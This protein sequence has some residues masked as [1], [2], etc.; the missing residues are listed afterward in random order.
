MLFDPLLKPSE[1]PV[2]APSGCPVCVLATIRSVV[3]AKPA[4]C[5]E[6]EGIQLTS[7][8]AVVSKGISA[9][10]GDGRPV[11]STVRAVGPQASQLVPK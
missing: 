3:N 6:G 2:I 11:I 7:P 4:V 1:T 9:G 5:G 8:P 10:G